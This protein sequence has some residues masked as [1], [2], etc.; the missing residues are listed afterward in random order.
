[1]SILVQ[2]SFAAFGSSCTPGAKAGLYIIC[3]LYEC[4]HISV[5]NSN[6]NT[7]Y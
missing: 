5:L 2:C 4:W 1:M 7:A 6:H 3:K